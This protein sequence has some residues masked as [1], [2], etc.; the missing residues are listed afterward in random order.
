MKNLVKTFLLTI[1]LLSSVAQG[2]LRTSVGTGLWSAAGTWD[3]GVPTNG[4]TFN[5]ANT[6]VVTMDVDQSG[7]A[8]GMGASTIAAG[9]TLISAA[10][11]GTYHLKMSNYLDVRGTLQAGT[12]EAVPLPAIATFTIDFTSSGWGIYTNNA[13]ANGAIKLYCL[14]PTNQYIK[15]TATEPIA[16]TVLA[17]DTDVTADTWKATDQ[18]AIV[19]IDE[20]K[21]V[22]IRT[23]AGG[24]IAA[25]AIT[26]TAGLTAEKLEGSYV[27][28]ITRNVR[29]INSN[30]A[31]DGVIYGS[32]TK[33]GY[34]IGAEFNT[35]TK[36]L[37]GV[38][39]SEFS[40][41]MATMASNGLDACFALTMSGAMVNGAGS[42][43]TSGFQDC[44]VSGLI[45]GWANGALSNF[46]TLYSGIVAGCTTGIITDRHPKITGTV[47]GCG[48]AVSSCFRV[49]MLG[50]IKNNVYGVYREGGH[51]IQGTFSNN[52][53]GD[54]REIY[55]AKCTNTTFGSATEF[56]TY[57]SQERAAY[58]YVESS[59]HDG[60]DNAFKA[61]CKGGI[62][63]SQTTSPPTGY[64]IWYEHA[65]EDTTQTYSCFRQF[66]TVVLPGTAIEVDGKIRI[67]DGENM[68]GIAPALQIIDFFDDPLVDS[69]ATPLDEDEIPIPTGDATW[70]DVSVIWANAG[71]SPRTV[72]VRMIVYHDGGGNDV[73]IDEVWSIANYQ[74]QIQ[75]IYDKLPTNYIMG[76]S[77]KDNH[78]TDIDSILEDTAQIGAGVSLDSGTATI[79][80]MLTKIADDNDGADF[81]A[82][83]D[84]LEVI[85]SRGDLAW[86]TGIGATPTHVYQIGTL[87]R[88][89]GDDDGGTIADVNIVDGST[90]DTGEIATTTKLEVDATFIA[91]HEYDTPVS[92]DLWGYY[93][94]GG[95]HYMIVQAYNYIDST[96]EEIGTI[97][98]SSAVSYYAFAMT[99]QHI[100]T[101]TGAMAIKLLHSDHTGIAA[102][103]MII[104]K[105]IVSTSEMSQLTTNVEAILADT[106]EIQT[107][108][109]DAGRLDVIW[110]A[111][112]ADTNELQ[113]DWTNGGRL[114]LLIDAIKLVTDRLPMI[115]TTVS[116]A[117]DANS[118]TLTAGE[119]A[120]DIYLGNTISIQDADD[121]HWESRMI[122]SWTSARVV[123]VDEY[124]SFTP[125]VGDVVVIWYSYYPMRAYWEIPW[126]EPDDPIIIDYRVV[127][128]GGSTGGTRTL[129]VTGD[130]P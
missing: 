39:G 9:G 16:E 82:G 22:E 33:T 47:D 10:G 87:T 28:L 114:D 116:D 8:A 90:F 92:V 101:S 54:L 79:A 80:G 68:T 30:N 3:T 109:V 124:F 99:P 34:H 113:T 81:N 102:H 117:N 85:R 128:A 60:V 93:A 56:F 95:G 49:Q 123:V 62:V 105:I 58:D 46:G 107:D 91:K 25:G 71:D 4:D 61:W 44:I 119:D 77:D 108:Q 106:N 19:N 118:C 24:G 121:S 32:L 1:L 31:T 69:T 64:T 41:T 111:I 38:R 7:M 63:T 94:G 14:Q 74:T 67:A 11:A 75:S 29:I 51:V 126:H 36:G 18:I 130:D 59:N 72:I 37:V 98:N 65:A 104:D 43:I 27:V 88:T 26:I 97:G 112:L 55:D 122:I 21:D 73:D 84:S 127:P 125:A 78:D 13:A 52:S 42:G 2:A 76:S 100:N 48:T 57:D 120:N 20:G 115:T 50:T 129:D 45:G 53:G 23:I 70:Q 83:R 15:L 35:C 96:F 89:V 5:I 86:T 66:V 6:H 17:V 110:D 12:S 40:G 103:V